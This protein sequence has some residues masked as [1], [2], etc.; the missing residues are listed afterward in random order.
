M[1]ASVLVRRDSP[2]DIKMRGLELFVDGELVADRQYGR[3]KE[4]T[5][6]EGEHEVKVTNS[7]YTKKLTVDLQPNQK[8]E[9]QAGNVATGL[10]GLMLVTFGIGPYKVF[11]KRQ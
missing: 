9:L 6:P 7:L 3:E 5:L 4:L 11:L 10:S 2:N 8:I 1:S